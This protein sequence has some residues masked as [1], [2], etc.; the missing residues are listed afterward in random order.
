MKTK[1]GNNW[2]VAELHNYTE[3]FLIEIIL[4]LYNEGE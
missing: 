2:Y 3:D 1:K 4:D